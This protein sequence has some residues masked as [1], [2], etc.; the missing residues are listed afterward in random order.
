FLGREELEDG[1]T[2]AVRVIDEIGMEQRSVEL[3]ASLSV[4]TLRSVRTEVAS[5]S[6]GQRQSV[7]IARSLLGE[8]KVVI[9]D[10]PTAALGV[11]QTKQV[12]D[13]VLR[14]KERGLGVMLISP[15]LL[16]VFEVPDRM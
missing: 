6:G 15:H 2:A 8:P 9:L 3:L 14:L 7:A 13:L 1:P 16:D 4:T 5:L 11:A 10:E 12:L